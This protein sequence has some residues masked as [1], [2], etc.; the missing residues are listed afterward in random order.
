MRKLERL[1]IRG[2]K[3]IR[4]QTLELDRLN[5]FIGG[6]GVGKS[7]LIGAFQFLHEVVHERLRKY[8]VTR[9]GADNILHF[10][11]KMTSNIE[12]DLMFGDGSRTNSYRLEIVGTEDSSLVIVSEST[13][14][15]ASEE[16]LKNGSPNA[17]ATK[18]LH[19]ADSAGTLEFDGNFTYLAE[20][21]LLMLDDF[22]DSSKQAASDLEGCRV[23]HFHDTGET[24]KMKGVSDIEDNRVLRPQAENLAAFLYYLQEKKPDY[25]SL[26][27]DTVRQ[28]AP[29]FGRFQLEPRRLNESTI[30]LEW[31]EKGHDGYFNASSFSDGTLRFICLATLLLQPELPTVLLLDEPEL[32]LHPAAVALLADLLV[33]ASEKTQVLVATQSVTLINHLTPDQVWTV[34]REENQTVFNRLNQGD[35]STWLDDYSLGELWEKN[36]I[37]ARP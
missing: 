37:K 25:F 34:N 27:E 23:Y 6:N 9:G 7:N 12:F 21:K 14:G 18:F 28:I 8:A 1:T 10:G 35:Y 2:F 3:S 30:R 20:S 11:R 31:Q 26:I 24:A 15:T 5:V 22:S 32:G 13:W 17:S 36:L 29:F 4:E 16:D 19:D 33:A